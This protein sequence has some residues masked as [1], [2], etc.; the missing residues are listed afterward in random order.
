MTLQRLVCPGCGSPDFDQNLR[1]Q[2]C[3]VARQRESSDVGA[4]LGALTPTCPD[5]GQV[6]RRADLACGLCGAALVLV[7]PVCWEFHRIGTKFCTRFP[8]Q[9]LEEAEKALGALLGRIRFVRIPP[10]RFVMG[11]SA[12]GYFSFPE[13]GRSE[14]ETQHEVTLTKGFRLAR[15]PVTVEQYV[16]LMG[17]VDYRPG[18]PNHPVVR[19]TWLEAARYCNALSRRMGLDEVY[20]FNGDLFTWKRDRERPGYRLPTEAEWE[21]AC[22]AGTK[23]ARYGSLDEVG[24]HSGNSGHRTHPVGRKKP[25]AWGLHDMLGGVYE[26][27]FGLYG[28]YPQS[29]VTDP[30]GRLEGASVNAR[31]GSY[32]HDG[33]YAR[34]ASRAH[35]VF[36]TRVES[37]GFR[38]VLSEP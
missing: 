23:G 32:L 30:L 24:W 14:D 8:R 18:G 15:T 12:G 29:A 28:P 25:N 7:C 38:L 26:W 1:C 13:P 33:Q 6:G 9:S 37:L 16:A 5:C 10:G 11:S 27:C 17:S 4:R 34:A 2:H 35:Q 19:V 3:G 31:G 20:V 21:Y 36:N 22:R